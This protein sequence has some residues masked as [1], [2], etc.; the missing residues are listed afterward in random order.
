MASTPE[1]LEALAQ[2]LDQ[3]PRYQLLDLATIRD[4]ADMTAMDRYKSGDLVR[5]ARSGGGWSLGVVSER[6]PDDR[7]RLVVR[8]Q[9]S[10][11]IRIKEQSESSI[12]KTN[13]L[14]IGDYLQIATTPFWVTGLDPD[15][16]LVVVTHAAKRVLASE[17]RTRIE[18]ELRRGSRDG[19]RTLNLTPAELARLRSAPPPANLPA[20]PGKPAP[21][22]Y[23]P[24]EQILRADS[25]YGL[26]A[27]NRETDT[28][29]NL[30]SPIAGA[31]LHTNKGHNYKA[32]N[33]DSGALFADKRGRLY[34]GVFDQAGGEGSDPNARGAA[35]AIAAQMMFDE[36]H[37]V[38]DSGGDDKAAETGLIRAATRAHEAI[39][40]RGKGEVTTY[41]GAMID[42]ELALIVNVGD[43]GAQHYSPTG[44]HLAS[45]QQQGIGRVL[46]EGLGMIRKEIFNHAVYR[47]KVAKGDYLVFG[48]DGLFDSRMKAPEIGELI[49]AAGTA[50]DAT[51]KLRDVVSERMK[52]R[53]GKPDNLTV[54]VVRVGEGPQSV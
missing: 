36:M 19:D 25:S 51:R 5:V 4:A 40:A 28:V 6:I 42:R 37:R 11:E 38:A 39:L 17:L 10:G 16:E 13:P 43:S 2:R 30:A 3:E 12:K 54:V 35:S 41:V 48:S 45:T 1:E 15:G 47:W 53:T 49:A 27:G 9:T 32:W 52:A 8:D 50:A 31:A 7:L 18:G 29:F 46:L 21:G 23:V 44:Q 34:L 33:E 24:I 22:P 14:R 20:S 26:F